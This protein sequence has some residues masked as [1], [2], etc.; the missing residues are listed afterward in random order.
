MKRIHPASLRALAFVLCVF[1]LIYTVTAFAAPKTTTELKDWFAQPWALLVLMYLGALGSAL[2]TVSTA[3]RDGA[4]VTLAEYLGH[5]PETISAVVAVFFAWL[6]LLFT[7]QLNV[8]A[9]LAYGAVANTG[10]D[11]IRAGGRTTALNPPS[12]PKE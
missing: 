5:W 4:T 11:I 6:G 9:A 8:A 10:I 12:P 1:L 3:R 2:K 7:D